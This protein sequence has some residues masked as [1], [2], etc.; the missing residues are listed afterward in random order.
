MSATL[1]VLTQEVPILYVEMSYF[2]LKLLAL[3]L[4]NAFMGT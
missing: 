3:Y 2:N 1:M 4:E